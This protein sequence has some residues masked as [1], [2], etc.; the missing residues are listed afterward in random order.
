[1]T[2]VRT[3]SVGKDVIY[4]TV[5]RENL[6]RRRLF[7]GRP[8]CAGTL[9]I[10]L[11]KGLASASSECRNATAWASEVGQNRRWGAPRPSE[12]GHLPTKAGAHSCL[13][14]SIKGVAR[15]GRARARRDRDLTQAGRRMT[16]IAAFGL[17]R[18][19]IPFIAWV[20]MLAGRAAGGGEVSGSALGEG[21]TQPVNRFGQHR[22]LVREPLLVGFFGGQQPLDGLQFVLDQLRLVDSF[23]LRAFQ[24]PW[25]C[26][27]AGRRPAPCGSATGAPRRR[28]RLGVCFRSWRATARSSRFRSQS[29]V[30]EWSQ[31]RS[32]A[33]RS[34]ANSRCPG[35][36]NQDGS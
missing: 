15:D 21:L 3:G 24:G 8:Q 20:L 16:G 6:L 5:S 4:F 29:A 25:F 14:T 13:A 9:V 28:D 35:R 27:P 32:G 33:H 2:Q 23:L 7:F 19:W 11:R 36:A 31:A 18:W 30:A 22:N 12:S 34:A 1:M 10:H 26:R 17:R